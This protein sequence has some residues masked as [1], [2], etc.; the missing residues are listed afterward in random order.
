MEAH[1]KVDSKWNLNANGISILNKQK[2]EG[3]KGTL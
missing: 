2:K 1:M 3:A